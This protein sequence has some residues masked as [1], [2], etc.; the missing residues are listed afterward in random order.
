MSMKD[1]DD[2]LKSNIKGIG[3]ILLILTTILWG[4]T[5]IITITITEIVPPFFYIGIRFII[6]FLVFLPF[7]KRFKELIKDKIQRKISI[8]SGLYYFIS[9]FGG[10]DDN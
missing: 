4:T 9:I 5:F 6:G 10:A 7:F 8:I 3:E 2:R 1:I